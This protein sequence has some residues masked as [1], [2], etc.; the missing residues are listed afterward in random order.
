[1]VERCR[2]CSDCGVDF[3]PMGEAKRRVG[4]RIDTC[5]NCSEETTTKYLG[6]QSGD[7]KASG[8]TI[9]KFETEE[10]RETYRRM[11]WNNTGMNKGK[12]CQLGSHLSTTPN[13]KF[14]KIHEAGLG[15]NHKG[16][17]T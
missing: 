17:A 14:K 15:V 11:W 8:V 2:E 9:L 1:M 4:G 10:E 13:V 12:S 5:A 16:K 7:G 3:D 6:L